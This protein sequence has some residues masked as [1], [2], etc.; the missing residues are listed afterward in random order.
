MNFPFYSETVQ[1][2][3]TNKNA[4]NANL[5]RDSSELKVKILFSFVIKLIRPP[6]PSFLVEICS[7]RRAGEPR[8]VTSP[9]SSSSHCS[10][11]LLVYLPPPFGTVCTYS[12]WL[13]GKQAKEEH[14]AAPM[15]KPM[16]ASSDFDVSLWNYFQKSHLFV[17]AGSIP[18]EKNNLHL[19]HFC[20]S[21]PTS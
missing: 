16:F 12:T 18:R 8:P 9:H 14:L 2:K 5:V 13:D 7:H 3:H 11:F 6:A 15:P 21:N 4:T 1:L 17:S 19:L 20:T 10:F